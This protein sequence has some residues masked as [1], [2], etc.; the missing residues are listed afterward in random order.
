[1]HKAI[2]FVI[3]LMKVRNESKVRLFDFMIRL[4]QIVIYDQNVIF[5]FDAFRK[6]EEIQNGPN[7]SNHLLLLIQIFFIACNS[8]NYVQTRVELITSV[9]ATPIR[10]I[11]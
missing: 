11:R 8:C 5:E 1:M 4:Q 9:D 6:L 2:I 7:G 3:D 10:I